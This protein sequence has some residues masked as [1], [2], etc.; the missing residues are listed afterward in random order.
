MSLKLSELSLNKKGE[1]SRTKRK[2]R[3]NPVIFHLLVIL[4]IIYG[5][6]Y[7]FSSDFE[8]DMGTPDENGQILLVGELEDFYQE[9]NGNLKIKTGEFILET[10]TSKIEEKSK[11]FEIKNFKGSFFLE[12]DELIF[13]GTAG[14][15]KYDKNELKLAPQEKFE[16]KT[17]D[18]TSFELYFNNLTLYF[19]EGRVKIDDTLNYEFRNSTIQLG[20]S[21]LTISYDGKFSFA[22]T[23]KKFDLTSPKQNLKII[24]ESEQ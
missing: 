10:Q 3:F 16:L 15:I 19:N 11:E 22:G 18:K 24:F 7:F 14:V 17:L 8:I 23:S 20:D 21:N 1:F 4:L 6:Y 5:I 12:N 2:H 13:Y 9:Y